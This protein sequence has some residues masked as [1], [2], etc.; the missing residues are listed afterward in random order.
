MRKRCFHLSGHLPRR[1]P[2]VARPRAALASQPLAVPCRA[3]FVPGIMRL[4]FKIWGDL[5]RLAKMFI[6]LAFSAMINN[7][8][9][10]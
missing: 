9:Q 2:A 10:C 8:M 1:A 3:G 5:R 7:P 4:R 6:A